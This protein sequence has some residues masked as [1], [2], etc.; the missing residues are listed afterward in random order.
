MKKKILDILIKMLG[1]DRINHWYRVVKFYMKYNIFCGRMNLLKCSR[2]HMFERTG[3]K[4]LFLLGTPVHGNLGDQAIAYAESIFLTQNFSDYE[5]IELDE[6]KTLEYL[7]Y[8]KKIVCNMDIIMLHGGGNMGTNYYYQEKERQIIIRNFPQN[9]IIIFPQTIDY[10]S[11]EKDKRALRHSCKVY[12]SHKDL[13]IAAREK[14]SFHRMERVYSSARVLLMPDIVLSLKIDNT[15]VRQ[16]EK[17]LL[18][19]RSDVEK[20]VSDHDKKYI[21]DKLKERGLKIE[22]SDT[23]VPNDISVEEREG[24]L[25]KKWREFME[26]RLVVTDRLHGMIFSVITGTPCIAFNNSNQKVRNCYEWISSIPWICFVES[27]DKFEDALDK[28][29]QNN[30]SFCYEPDLLKYQDLISSISEG[31]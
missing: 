24:E 18:C 22:K 13:T 4:R 23:V 11:S 2:E 26:S 1:S 9:K 10:G 7:L 8:L 31:E 5:L 28:I 19:M 17:V 25:Q 15:S 14:K 29:L 20:A 6:D 27:A 30:G 16:R 3:K 12:R 21:T